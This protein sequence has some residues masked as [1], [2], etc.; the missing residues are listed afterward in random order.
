MLMVACNIVNIACNGPP[1]CDGKYLWVEFSEDLVC[2]DELTGRVQCFRVRVALRMIDNEQRR[3][4][5]ASAGRSLP[6]V[7]RERILLRLENS[8]M[9]PVDFDDTAK[10][11][12][13][14]RDLSAIVDSVFDRPRIEVGLKSCGERVEDMTEEELE[15]M[16]GRMDEETR[17][18]LKGLP[19]TLGYVN[20]D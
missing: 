9:I 19:P 2:R 1:V 12:G 14:R 20:D 13:L 7:L 11:V 3:L 18:R 5:S 15:K 8:G 10:V 4:A 16:F 17:R 6:P